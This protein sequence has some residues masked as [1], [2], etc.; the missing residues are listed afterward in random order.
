MLYEAGFHDDNTMNFNFVSAAFTPSGRSRTAATAISRSRRY[1]G[2]AFR[3]GRA[4]AGEVEKRIVFMGH[5]PHAGRAAA[6]GRDFM[7]ADEPRSEW[8]SLAELG[9][10]EASLQAVTRRLNQ[11]IDLD[12]SLHR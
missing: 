1:P 5:A 2:R 6:L 4:V 3:V 7:Q 8:H 12:A 11:T 9:P 10:V